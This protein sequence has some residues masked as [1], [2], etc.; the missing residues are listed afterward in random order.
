MAGHSKWS[1]IKRQKGVKDAKRGKTNTRLVREIM[2][3][4][5]A[6]GPDKA[7]NAML[8]LAV[9]RANKANVT[10]DVIEKA[11]LKATGQLQ[12]EELFEISYEGYGPSGVAFWVHCMSDNK[13][14]T[15]SEVRYAFSR[16]GG[17]LG[18]S[19]SVAYLFNRVA[20]IVCE[21]TDVDA[22]L[23]AVLD[24]DVEN[25]EA[26]GDDVIITAEASAL[27]DVCQALEGWEISESEVT[28]LPTSEVTLSETEAEKV[29]KL[30]TA[31]EELDDVQAV[32]TNMMVA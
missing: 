29:D 20:K 3:A 19:G 32:Y 22:V 1:N 24:Y 9:E 23:E 28:Y 10:K 27:N 25:V 18:A 8:R 16:A 2:V 21:K 30:I 26:D 11:I 17:T 13:N 4:A 12:G 6:G 5:K 31:L 7:T 15:V 14:R